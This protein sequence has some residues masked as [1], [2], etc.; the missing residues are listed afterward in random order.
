MKARIFNIQRNS[1]HDGP[2]IRTT[3]FLKGCPLHCP[4]CCN[5]ESQQTA[6]FLYRE[7]QKCLLCYSC[8][9]ACKKQAIRLEKN[10]N[11][12]ID[13][14]S[15][16]SCQ[17]K[18]CLKACPSG[19]LS[20]MGEEKT[21]EEVE[22]EA[23]RDWA[24]YQE[25]EG[26]IT[27]SGGEPLLWAE[28]IRELFVQCH[29]D[30]FTTAIETCLH[31][32][33]EQLEKILSVTDYFFCDY[34]HYDRELFYA[35]TGGDLELI[36]RNLQTVLK[37]GKQVTVRIPL[38]PG[39]N[40]RTETLEKMC[41]R[42]A[43]FGASQVELLPYHRLGQIKYENMNLLYPMKNVNLLSHQEIETLKKIPY[44]YQLRQPT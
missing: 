23:K 29:Q 37:T 7:R 4:W 36:E 16:E 10:G 25:G 30:G 27:V 5:P 34:K 38:I 6:P 2:G 1:I 39:F 42:L 35:W 9:A 11:Q 19:A 21:V 43:E 40:A 28:F 31:G 24:F 18:W 3:V 14:K 33:K 20:W 41:E 15:C 22:Q 13:T 12:S 26:G 44:Q 17:E 32:K 8:T